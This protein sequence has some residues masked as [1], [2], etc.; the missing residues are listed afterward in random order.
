MKLSHRIVVEKEEES[1]VDTIIQLTSDLHQLY[2]GVFSLE[3]YLTSK[4]NGCMSCS[5]VSLLVIQFSR[6][7][8]CGMNDDKIMMVSQ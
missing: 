1:D 3:K 5:C 8:A 7:L 4:R 6:F 2:L